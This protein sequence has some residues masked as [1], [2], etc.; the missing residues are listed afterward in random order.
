M[1]VLEW[2]T[3]SALTRELFWCLF[4]ELRSNK[5]VHK[6]CVTRVH[7]L[8]YFW[9]D[10]THPQM[11]I[12]TTIFTHGPVVSLARFTFS[13][14]RHIRLLTSQWPD[15][16]EAT[17][18]IMISDSLDIDFIHDDVHGRSC[19]N[20]LLYYVILSI[21]EVNGALHNTKKIGWDCTLFVW[22]SVSVP[23]PRNDVLW[24]KSTRLDRLI[25][26]IFTNKIA[27]SM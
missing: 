26:E 5:W 7:T 20:V 18:R 27:C 12:E 11:T 6:Q 9:H 17:T 1:Y 19:N 16:S 2:R 22:I 8:F 10:I 15:N 23:A 14:W 24:K 21:G 13:S 4:P 25:K 3:V